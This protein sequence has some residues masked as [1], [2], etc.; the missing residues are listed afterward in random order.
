MA[1]IGNKVGSFKYVSTIGSLISWMLR[2]RQR[3]QKSGRGGGGNDR[4]KLDE[5]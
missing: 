4:D 3:T 5:F 1:W 2:Q